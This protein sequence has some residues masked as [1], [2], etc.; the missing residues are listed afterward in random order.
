MFDWVM[1]A[2]LPQIFA[3]VQEPMKNFQGKVWGGAM[4]QR[5]DISKGLT[6]EQGQ[7]LM[8]YYANGGTENFRNMMDYT[9][10]E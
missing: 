8:A 2:L 3:Q 7:R 5:P 6:P 4:W 10:R 1:E 9:P